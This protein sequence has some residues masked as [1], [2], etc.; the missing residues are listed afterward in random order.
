MDLVKNGMNDV[1]FL[2]IKKW[3]CEVIPMEHL[4]GVSFFGGSG[5]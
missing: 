2:G 1:L 5:V 4:G 3:S